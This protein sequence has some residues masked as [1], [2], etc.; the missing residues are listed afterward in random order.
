MEHVASWKKA[1]GSIGFYFLTHTRTRDPVYFA[2]LADRVG[3]FGRPLLQL[4][5]VFVKPDFA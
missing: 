4:Q 1:Y 2:S 5:H 3:D